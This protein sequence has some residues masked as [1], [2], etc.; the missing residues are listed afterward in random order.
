M[1][2][3]I[4]GRLKN[5]RNIRNVLH[6]S[7]YL[8][9]HLSVCSFICKFVSPS[10][11]KVLL[12]GW[13]DRTCLSLGIRNFQ[14]ITLSR[15]IKKAFLWLD[16]CKLARQKESERER[17]ERERGERERGALSFLPLLK[18]KKIKVPLFFGSDIIWGRYKLFVILWFH[19]DTGKTLTSNKMSK[20][21]YLSQMM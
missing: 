5:I 13:H 12:A 16:R 21:S 19:E 14:V 20:N 6:A 15:S 17:E 2:R 11:G 3:A 10:V 18:L 9:V 4:N 8:S 1:D 7:A